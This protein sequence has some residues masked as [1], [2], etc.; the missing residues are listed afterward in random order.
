M[1]H[2]FTLTYLNGKI[3][4]E[5]AYKKVITVKGR[6][7]KKIYEEQIKKHPQ[8]PFWTKRARNIKEI[9]PGILEYE[10]DSECLL[11]D[12]EDI[13]K[14]VEKYGNIIINKPIKVGSGL[15]QLVIYNDYYE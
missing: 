12:V 11:V 14:F 3:T 13:V 2:T 1:K 10:C 15:P 4:V 6:I 8:N 9:E 5:E 7:K